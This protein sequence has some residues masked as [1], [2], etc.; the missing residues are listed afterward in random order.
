MRL[1]LPLAISLVLA[2][3]MPAL[4]QHEGHVMPPPKPAA[5][6]TKKKP[7]PAKPVAKPATR[8]VAKAKPAATP[9]P[10]A[11][12][13]QPPRK[14]SASVATPAAVDHS[15]MDHSKM[16]GMDHSKM[17]HSKME[18]MDHSKM[19]HSKMEGMDH[20]PSA[21]VAPIPP[22]TQADRDAG[23]PVVHAH[24]PHGTSIH[25]YWLL[26][27]LEVSDADD[28]TALGWEATAWVG[29]DIQRL[30]LRSEGEA[31]D[32]RVEHGDVEVLYGRGVRAWWDVLAGVR[33]DVGEGPSRTWAAFGVQGLAPYKF[34]VSATAYI[35]QG[36]RTALRVE[37]EYD[38]LLTNRLILQWRAEANAHGKDDP[39]AMVGAGL[40]TVEAGA[41]L[42]YE[43]TRQFAPY[44][45]FEYGRAFG[46]TADMRRAAGHDAGG[47]TRVV[48]GVRVWF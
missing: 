18:G 37:A 43:I 46:T 15:T 2:A 48:A 36:G 41:R 13:S 44:I 39:L 4:A 21:S 38:T 19:D 30:W 3:P 22:L 16:E 20:S 40:S 42:R 8:P 6:S 9:K 28:G 23:F 34:E 7:S 33:Q 11:K 14:T 24:H 45:G 1:I 31:V 27:R 5:T 17:D 32:G 47:D 26:D 12:A 10:S 25:S 35:G 29:G